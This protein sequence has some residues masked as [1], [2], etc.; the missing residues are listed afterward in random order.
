[1]KDIEENEKQAEIKR[2]MITMITNGFV[3]FRSLMSWFFS[4]ESCGKTSA[5][6]LLP[7]VV[8]FLKF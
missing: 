6:L 3:S 5:V 2:D 4:S 1:M 7:E 8:Y